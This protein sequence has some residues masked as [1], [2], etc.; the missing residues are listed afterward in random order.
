M[1]KNVK[2]LRAVLPFVA[3]HPV[4]AEPNRQDNSD[5]V[6]AIRL[7]RACTS[8]ITESRAVGAK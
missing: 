7:L 4:P 5:S 8:E 2:D 3:S 1:A 6:G